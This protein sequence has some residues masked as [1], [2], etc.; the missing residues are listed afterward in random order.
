MTT[1]SWHALF[2][3]FLLSVFLCCQVVERLVSLQFTGTGAFKDVVSGFS[4][5]SCG[6]RSLLCRHTFLSFSQVKVSQSVRFSFAFLT[7]FINHSHLKENFARPML[8]YYQNKSLGPQRLENFKFSTWE[9][10][11]GI[12]CVEVKYLGRNGNGCIPNRIFE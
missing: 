9:F 7:L 8:L 10:A 3:M 1:F 4:R 12:N 11:R 5:T 2:K 6:K